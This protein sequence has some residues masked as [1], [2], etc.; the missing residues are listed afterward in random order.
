MPPG[1]NGRPS[2]A[3]MAD[4]TFASPE[5]IPN[6]CQPETAEANSLAGSKN[7]FSNFGTVWSDTIESS[8]SRASLRW[9]KKPL[10]IEPVNY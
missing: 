4:S 8:D 6:P 1:Q 5:A 10:S 2:C 7:L 9:T 3:Q